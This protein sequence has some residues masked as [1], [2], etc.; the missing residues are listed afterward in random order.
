MSAEDT[1]DDLSCVLT[2][3]VKKIHQFADPFSCWSNITTPIS[4]EEIQKAIDNFNP[5]TTY[6]DLKPTTNMFIKGPKLTE[7]ELRQAHIQKIAY[8]V[9]KGVDM[10]IDIDVGIPGY[11]SG[12]E[13]IIA[14]GNHRLAAAIFRGDEYIEAEWCGCEE[15]FKNYDF[16]T[17][18]PYTSNKFKMK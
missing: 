6:E 15:T 11:G 9:L 8:M 4:F 18:P 16:G 2:C 5:A 1:N 14:D 10:K 7:D 3:S 17:P 12:A 13:H